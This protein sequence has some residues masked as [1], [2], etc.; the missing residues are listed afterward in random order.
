MPLGLCSKENDFLT[1]KIESSL[2]IVPANKPCSFYTCLGLKYLVVVIK[3]QKYYSKYI[4][5]YKSSYS[6]ILKMPSLSK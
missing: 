5:Y 2:K 3:K 1:K 6:T 4:Y